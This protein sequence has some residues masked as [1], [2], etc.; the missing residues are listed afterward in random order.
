[1]SANKRSTLPDFADDAPDL[2]TPEWREKFATAPVRRGRPP[3][4][5]RKIS[6]TI[7]LDPEVLE[8]FKATGPGWQTLINETLR[9]DA[10]RRKAKA[11]G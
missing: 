4:D 8:V 10:A 6:T 2:S 11:S 1:M 9:K 3:A 7:R 5:R